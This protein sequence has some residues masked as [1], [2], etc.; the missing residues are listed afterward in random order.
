MKKIALLVL[1]GIFTACSE[2]EEVCRDNCYKILLVENG[3]RDCS[4]SSCRYT[5]RLMLENTCTKELSVYKTRFISIGQR[6]QQG[7]EICS[8][9]G[10]IKQ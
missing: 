7:S 4:V 10:L 8:L 9:T 1:I 2:N 3:S 5:F 6:P